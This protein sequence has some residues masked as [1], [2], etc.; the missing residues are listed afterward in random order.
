MTNINLHAHVSTSSR[1]CDGPMYREYVETLTDADRLAIVAANGINDFTDLEFKAR[2]LS[3]HVSF[4]SEFGVTVRMD[5]DGFQVSEPTDEGH[6]SSEVTWC[7]NE[8]CDP[9]ARWQRDVY[10]EAMGY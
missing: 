5:A 4:H 3:F 7:E 8:G 6:R 1:D 2:I 9:N 10:A